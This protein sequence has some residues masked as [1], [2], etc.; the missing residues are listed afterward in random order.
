M[1]RV[2]Y[3]SCS[4]ICRNYPFIYIHNIYVCLHTY[5][6]AHFQHKGRKMIREEAKGSMREQEDGWEKSMWAAKMNKT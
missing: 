3:L 6:Y 1:E 4:V 2:N 5:T